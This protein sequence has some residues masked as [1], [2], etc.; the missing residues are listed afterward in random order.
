MTLIVSSSSHKTN[1]HILKGLE[2]N[3]T[4]RET[5]GLNDPLREIEFCEGV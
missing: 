2:S 4:E 5:K 1:R 3:L